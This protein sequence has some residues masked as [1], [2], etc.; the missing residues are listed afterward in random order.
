MTAADAKMGIIYRA[1]VFAQ[2]RHDIVAAVIDDI[3][4]FDM[5]DSKAVSGAVADKD[6]TRILD[7]ELLLIGVAWTGKVA[8]A[9]ERITAE[10][11]HFLNQQHRVILLGAPK[12]TGESRKARANDNDIVL[13]IEFFDAAA[14][15]RGLHSR[16]PGQKRRAAG[17]FEEMASSGLHGVSPFS[18]LLSVFCFILTEALRSAFAKQSMESPE[19]EASPA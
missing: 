17:E 9:D 8:A 16:K 18:I 19:R 2:E 6:F 10:D 4:Q 15:N 3:E 14:G 13:L 5:V 1:A 11:R 7:P 12:R